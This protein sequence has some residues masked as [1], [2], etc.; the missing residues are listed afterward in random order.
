MKTGGLVFN[1]EN[2]QGLTD[3]YLLLKP[4]TWPMQVK[5]PLSGS[6]FTCNTVL[7]Q[8]AVS[9]EKSCQQTTQR[10][11]K[12]CIKEGLPAFKLTHISCSR[13]NL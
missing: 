11:K 2:N 3:C 12:F 5:H 7:L 6:L 1:W 8:Q 4:Y 10:S 13:R 9:P